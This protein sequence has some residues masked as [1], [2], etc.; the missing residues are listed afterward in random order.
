MTL[1]KN[2]FDAEVDKTQ[3][4]PT[5]KWTCVFS[6]FSQRNVPLK[7][8]KVKIYLSIFAQPSFHKIWANIL[9]KLLNRREYEA[10]FANIKSQSA[11]SGL[12]KSA[13]SSHSKWYFGIEILSVWIHSS[14]YHSFSFRPFSLFWMRIYVF[15][16]R[17]CLF[18]FCE[19]VILETSESTPESLIST[20]SS[21]QPLKWKTT[22]RIVCKMASFQ[23]LYKI[24]VIVLSDVWC[25]GVMSEVETSSSRLRRGAKVEILWL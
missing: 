13:I 1:K 25:S 6:V 23:S 24:L 22:Q 18:F 12:T 2:V 17:L 8:S 16:G 4:V 15:C 21:H 10:C 5:F 11:V 14:K 19:K 3:K 9:E 20:I 7:K